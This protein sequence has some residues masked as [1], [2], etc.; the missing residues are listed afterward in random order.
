MH[1]TRTMTIFISASQAQE[2]AWHKVLRDLRKERRAVVVVPCHTY[3]ALA[4]GEARRERRRDVCRNT[5]KKRGVV[6][7]IILLAKQDICSTSP[8][9]PIIMPHEF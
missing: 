2:D 4:C 9:P 7:Q 6:D 8:L 1:S 5:P 3:L